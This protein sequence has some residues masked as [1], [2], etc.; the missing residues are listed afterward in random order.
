[1][2]RPSTGL[3][4]LS[5]REWGECAGPER[6]MG[7]RGDKD[8]RLK[9]THK[10]TGGL[11]G[12]VTDDHCTVGNDNDSRSILCTMCWMLFMRSVFKE[13]YC[14]FSFLDD[15]QMLFVTSVKA[16]FP[17]FGSYMTDFLLRVAPPISF[18]VVM[19]TVR[20]PA[21]EICKPSDGMSQL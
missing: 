1:M 19:F 8:G 15:I 6:H 5:G 2:W 9:H 3:C 18:S 14:M 20:V 4:R 17:E 21:D 7:T 13:S 16:T 10:N 11:A 12:T